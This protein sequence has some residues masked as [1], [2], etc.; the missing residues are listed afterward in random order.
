MAIELSAE[1]EYSPLWDNVLV[2]YDLLDVS[3]GGGLVVADEVARSGR[4][5]QG[6]VV[7][8]GPDAKHVKP[9]MRVWFETH[10]A[11]TREFESGGR[12]Y[13]VVKETDIVCEMRQP[14]I[15]SEPT[16]LKI[17]QVGKA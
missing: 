9:G 17:S 16:V 3:I 10:A 14:G 12:E 11:L 13:A 7:C 1:W 5:P 6:T 15:I 8:H 2:V 4:K